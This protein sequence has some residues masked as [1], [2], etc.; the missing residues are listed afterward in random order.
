MYW[1]ISRKMKSGETEPVIPP[2]GADF[3]SG[4]IA[5]AGR[6]NVGKSTLLN[7]LVNRKLA[8]VSPKPQTTRHLTMGVLNGPGFQAIL[9]DTP[10]LFA[11]K[12]SLKLQ[13]HMV[14]KAL[15][16]LEEADV[17]LLMAEPEISSE[18]DLP[19]A[20]IRNILKPVVL[21]INKID[22]VSKGILLPAIGS[23]SRMYG[24]REIVPISALRAD[25]LELLVRVTTDLLP[26]GSP[27]FPPDVLTDKPERFF[28]SEIIRESIFSSY[29]QEIPYTTTVIIEDFSERR[30]KK[31]YIR[32]TIYTERDSQK[33]ILIGKKGAALKRAGERARR[34]IEDFLERPVYLELWVK[35]R[36]DW[37]RKEGDLREFGY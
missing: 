18:R 7:A 17:I 1:R 22:T 10:G 9:V 25:G 11:P 26:L 28:V 8:I 13:Q 31:D 35:T 23:A 14:K 19:L 12:G 3:R 21:A 29:G 24:F 16:A 5:L 33:A 34:E 6:P 2:A 4:Y 15:S 36:K 37:R 27:F 20:E 32:A 30:D